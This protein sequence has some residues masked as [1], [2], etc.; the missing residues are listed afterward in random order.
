MIG[1]PAP[2]ARPR[3]GGTTWQRLSHWVGSTVGVG[4]Y[5]AAESF[6]ELTE[7]SRQTAPLPKKFGEPESPPLSEVEARRDP[8]N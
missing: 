8:G 3:T 6:T 2:G 5:R 7:N 4:P 1:G